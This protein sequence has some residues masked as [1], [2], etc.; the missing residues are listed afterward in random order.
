M[1]FKNRRHRTYRLNQWR[2]HRFSW[3][4]A[5]GPIVAAGVLLAASLYWL[6]YHSR[7]SVDTGNHPSNQTV[8][9]RIE[10]QLAASLASKAYGIAAGSSLT[11]LDDTAL[12]QRMQAIADLGVGWVRYDFDWSLI[13][14]DD[15][16]HYNWKQYDR[17]VAASSKYNL[18]VLGILDYTPEWA[19]VSGCDGSQCAPAD[20][21]QFASFAG[22]VAKR[23]HSKG[24]HAWEVWN[25]P[26]SKDFWKPAA[27]P[28]AYVKLLQQT[29]SSVVHEDSKAYILTGGLSP[30]ATNGT[31]YTPI[32]F[33]NAIYAQGGAGYFDG[34][35][36]H[37]YTF[38][39]SPTSTE[40]HAWNQMA[41]STQSLRAT[42]VANG[43]TDKK[44]WIT[45][46]GAPTGG[47]GPLSTVENPNL[48]AQPYKVDDALQAKILK[49][50]LAL[51]TSY[52][53]VGPFFVYSYQDAGT[54]QDTN[55]N[56]FGLVRYD[57]SHKPAYDIY[58]AAANSL[59]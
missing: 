26:N 13:Q 5:V 33:L 43:D 18:Q 17:L 39:L 21:G 16:S 53:W 24:I 20:P 38:P 4:L 29:Y 48:D 23:Y 19:R 51:Y 56:F 37:P 31:S 27:N 3:R 2:R 32:D 46:F 40:D 10:P 57:G 6:V 30:Q 22:A 1:R 58:A 44:V 25:E 15:S 55:E 59:K 35:A 42:M 11:A 45:E 34:V 49:D 52:D 47:P 28:A 12:D 7:N 50:A 41:R 14:P 8:T 9:G 36:D 54:E